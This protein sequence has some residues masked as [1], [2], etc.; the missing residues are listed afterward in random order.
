M[1]GVL[2]LI[3]FGDEGTIQLRA[4]KSDVLL[5]LMPTVAD[6]MTLLILP[7]DNSRCRHKEHIDAF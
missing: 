5:L 1:I 2:R 3:V 4:E 7:H 6:Y